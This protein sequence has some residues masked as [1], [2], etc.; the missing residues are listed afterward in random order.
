MS[1]IVGLYHLDGRPVDPALLTLMT[2]AL[3]HRGPD[4]TGQWRDGPVGFGYRALYT[5]PESLHEKQ[6]LLDA[7]GNLC[8]VLDGRVDNRDDLRGALEAKGLHLRTDTDAELVLRAYECWGPESPARIIGDFAFAIWDRRERRLFCAR[9]A[10][11]IRPFY[12]HV[13]GDTFRFASELRQILIDPAV[14]REPN[15]GMI[16]EYLAE[17]IIDKEETLFRGI[18]R[19]PP[20]HSLT[21]HSG[22]IRKQRYWNIDPALEIKHGSDQEYAE[23]FLDIFRESVR[24]RLRSHGP[25]GADL[26]GGL[27]SSS[28]VCMAQDLYRKGLAADHGFETF[29]MVFPGLP[30]DESSFIQEVVDKWGVKSNRFCPEVVGAEFHVDRVLRDFD[31]PIY[32]NGTMHFGCYSQAHA[33]GMRVLLTGSGG[34]QW[35]QGNLWHL[36]DLL[37]TFR[38]GELCRQ[39]CSEKVPEQVRQSFPLLRGGFWPLVPSAARQA[40]RWLLRRDQVPDWIH[41]RLVR[42]AQLKT[43][44]RKGATPKFC[45]RYAADLLHKTLNGGRLVHVFECLDRSLSSFALE[46]RHPFHDRRLVEFALAIPEE[47]RRRAEQP[48]FVLRQAMRHLLPERIRQRLSKGAFDDFFAGQLRSPSYQE[49][50]GHLARARMDWVNS[51]RVQDINDQLSG[52]CA[53]GRKE[54]FAHYFPLWLVLAIEVWYNALF[55]GRDTRRSA[56]SAIASN[57]GCGNSRSHERST[58]A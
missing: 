56:D 53:N 1:G 8:L 47:Q 34:D 3:A 6:P 35:L 48:K 12:Y 25:V 7:T 46:G 50:M 42:R 55:S 44:L 51:A 20:A 29:S 31:C 36:A 17:R 22:C 40:I 57:G 24:C 9:D 19:L 43:R 49:I 5:T 26:S 52:L 11:G 2:D 14:D 21:I 33:K 15:E 4:G 38:L 13:A 28:V 32:P 30:C 23:H 16:A 54:Q 27:D 45:R 41:P 37:S 58:I 39:L 18:Y 10:I